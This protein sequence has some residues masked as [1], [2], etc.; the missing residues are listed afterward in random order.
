MIIKLKH[1][2]IKMAYNIMLTALLFLLYVC[3]VNWNIIQDCIL[4][5]NS[6]LGMHAWH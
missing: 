4:D 2:L 6:I 1:M 5:M 3:I